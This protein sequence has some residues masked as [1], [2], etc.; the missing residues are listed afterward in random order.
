MIAGS[1]Y[2]VGSLK[3]FYYSTT[4]MI[5]RQNVLLLEAVF[6]QGLILII[7]DFSDI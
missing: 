4:A 6:L 2:C 3:S 5:K 7:F 1:F